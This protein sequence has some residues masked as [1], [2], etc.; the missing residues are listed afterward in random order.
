MRHWWTGWIQIIGVW[1]M[2]L[3]S[4][5]LSSPVEGVI[6]VWWYWEAFNTVMPQVCSLAQPSSVCVCVWR[7]NSRHTTSD[8][9][10]VSS[11]VQFMSS[12]L[13]LCLSVSSQDPAGIFELVELVGNGTYGQV[14]KVRLA[15]LRCHVC[16][17]LPGMNTWT[18]TSLTD[19]ICCP[20]TPPLDFDNSWSLHFLAFYD[21]RH[22]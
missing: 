5:T 17:K 10:L 19:I 18:K 1:S 13:T 3:C 6:T 7:S 4:C 22:K 12:W 20:V 16:R 11:S 9:H 21:L 14:Y 2:F 15:I 8:I